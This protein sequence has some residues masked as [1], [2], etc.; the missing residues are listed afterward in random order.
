M[1]SSGT[2]SGTLWAVRAA[3]GQTRPRRPPGRGAYSR[4]V[5]FSKRTYF[6]LVGSTSS[7][8]TSFM[9]SSIVASFLG[10]SKIS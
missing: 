4:P 9:I 10:K 6:G 8:C 1:T 3:P 2:P 5:L 7:R